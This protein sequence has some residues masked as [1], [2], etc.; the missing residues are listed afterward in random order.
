[1]CSS[2]EHI[3]TSVISIFYYLVLCLVQIAFSNCTQRKPIVTESWGCS[4]FQ[5]LQAVCANHD[6][7]HRLCILGLISSGCYVCECF[8]A[9]TCVSTEVF[10][11]GLECCTQRQLQ[12]R[13]S[14]SCHFDWN[15]ETNEEEEERPD[16]I[17]EVVRGSTD[18]SSTA[19]CKGTSGVCSRSRAG[20]TAELQ[21]PNACRRNMQTCICV[22]QQLMSEL[23]HACSPCQANF[24]TRARLSWFVSENAAPIS[25]I[26]Y[27]LIHL[28]EAVRTFVK[29]PA[30][31]NPDVRVLLS[32]I[33]A[34]W[35]GMCH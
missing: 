20:D 27:E 33:T 7:M 21:Q 10:C 34:N 32:P 26:R 2:Y 9:H 8:C 13:L 5:L 25:Q 19:A 14:F 30:N 31:P 3:S 18:D 23:S 11:K 6:L 17:R 24:K 29:Q 35:S 1:M 28:M 15:E 16:L 22:R 12:S 4:A